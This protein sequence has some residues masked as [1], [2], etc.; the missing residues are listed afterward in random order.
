MSSTCPA[1]RGHKC[2]HGPGCFLDHLDQIRKMMPNT[3]AQSLAAA[4]ADM[5]AGKNTATSNTRRTDLPYR[6]M[7]ALIYKNSRF[8]ITRISPDELILLDDYKIS[9]NNNIA[10]LEY[11]LILHKIP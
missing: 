5:L 1:C 10:T 8:S 9:T 11:E 4:A 6:M 2:N 3:Y 7:K